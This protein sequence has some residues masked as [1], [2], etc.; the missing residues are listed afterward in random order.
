MF[1]KDFIFKV[2]SEKN[3]QTT[4]NEKITQHAELSVGIITF[5]VYFSEEGPGLGSRSDL[6]GG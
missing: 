6:G 2:N 1:L 4:K 5:I 3:Q